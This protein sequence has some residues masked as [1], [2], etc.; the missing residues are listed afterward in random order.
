MQ[1]CDVL[2][3]GTGIAGMSLA[4]KLIEKRPDFKMVMLS[5]GHPCETNTSLAQGGIAAVMDRLQDSFE[6]HIQDTLEAGHYLND[7]DVVHRVVRQAPARIQEL[8]KWGVTFDTQSEGSFAL[9]LEGG[10]SQPRI[11]H[12]KDK[13][14]QHI[15]DLLWQRIQETPQ[16]EIIDHVLVTSI[17]KSY[18]E[19]EQAIGLSYIDNSHQLHQRYASHIVLATGGCGQVFTHT[20]NP[21]AATGDGIAL[22][23]KAD[24]E[25]SDMQY[26]QF[27][28][29]ALYEPKKSN[30]FLISE[31]LRGFGAHVVNEQQE[32]FLF[33]FDIRG[34]LAPRDI[35]SQAI[36]SELLQT[37]KE[38]V[39]LDLRHL[40]IQALQEHFPTIFNRLHQA[41][42]QPQK[43]LIPIVP[44]AHYQC[45]GI[46]V[47]QHGR[48]SLLNL[49]A[50]GEC[51]HTGLHGSNRLASNS[52]LEALVY[53]HQIAEIISHQKPQ[54]I[55]DKL[56]RLSEIKYYNSKDINPVLL[57]LFK[58]EIKQLMD[59]KLL[60]GNQKEQQLAVDSLMKLHQDLLECL[61]DYQPC[62]HSYELENMLLTAMVI[63][64]HVLFHEKV[65]PHN[66]NQYV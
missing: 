52:L 62:K 18:Q 43:D 45:G 24:V 22:A 10:H 50:L 4:L 20:S 53:A 60:N 19:E 44:A 40:D 57:G 13:T 1:H 36:F 17:L 38:Q 61:G 51:A 54:Q 49:Y 59:Y 63:L 32:R 27:H 2:I 3:A 12:A 9:G 35:V 23:L 66:Q 39:F 33:Q 37:N 30:L 31:A 64:Q 15:Q 28:P 34:E 5:K 8:I 6:Q 58:N 25:L 29:T 14:G 56:K 26:I 16:I 42:Y 7:V 41:G 48:S 65:N 55:S 46:K 21:V 11:V 47:D